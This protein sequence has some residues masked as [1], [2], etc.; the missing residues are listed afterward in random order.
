MYTILSLPTYLL[1]FHMNL[2]KLQE[3]FSAED[4]EWRIG[5]AGLSLKGQ[6]YGTVLAYITNRA[7]QNRLDDVCGPA[8][9]RNEYRE[10]NVGGKPGVLCGISIRIGDEWVTKWDGAENTEIEPVKGGL[11]DSMKRAGVQWGIGRY[12]Y[13]LEENFAVLDEQG[14]YFAQGRD[15]LTG[16]PYR[17][18]W[19]PPKLPS[20]ALP[21]PSAVKVAPGDKKKEERSSG[22]VLTGT[23]AYE[24]E[25]APAGKRP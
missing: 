14:A 20:W 19:N 1:H 17:F 10:W 5:R 9:W 2:E 3:R 4:I 6:L 13:N 12:L 16:K 21:A 8:N 25:A 11:S 18:R 22:R 24:Q 23:T 7:I 15:K